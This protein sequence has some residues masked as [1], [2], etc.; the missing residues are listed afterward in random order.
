MTREQSEVFKRGFEPVRLLGHCSLRFLGFCA[1]IASSIFV[2]WSLFGTAFNKP[3]RLINHIMLFLFSVMA[4][5]IEGVTIPCVGNRCK[6]CIQMKFKIEFWAKFLSRAWGKSLLYFLIG[7]FLFLRSGMSWWI[8]G[9][10]NTIVGGIYL[11]YSIYGSYHLRDIRREALE[12]YQDNFEH[13]FE[14]ADVNK[15]GFLDYEEL[16]DLSE[17]IGL[18]LSANEIQ[19]LVNYL[20]SDR[21]GK[22]SIAEFKIWF[23]QN[24]IPTLI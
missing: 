18:H 12:L 8:C 11:L 13:M 14:E 6:C 15:D 16:H 24:K 17:K 1:A 7:S 9:L 4:T 21:D 3:W 5:I 2:G 19:V 20:D 22:V 23:E 10:T